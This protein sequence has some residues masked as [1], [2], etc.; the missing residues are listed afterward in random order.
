MLRSSALADGDDRVAGTD[1]PARDGGAVE[2]QMRRSRSSTR[3][4]LLAGSP[5][6]P[7][8]RT[9]FAAS[10]GHRTKLDRR[11]GTSPA[12]TA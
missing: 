5:S 6:A 9:T 10:G 4:F 7:L 2:Y 3:S 8:A 11:S 12:V 1:R